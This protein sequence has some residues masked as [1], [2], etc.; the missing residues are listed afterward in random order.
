MAQRR[1]AGFGWRPDLPDFRDWILAVDAEVDATRLPAH[2]DL[3]DAGILPGVYDQGNLGS[4]T[5]NA[6]SADARAVLKTQKLGDVDPSRLY[7]YYKEREAEGSTGEDSGAFIRDGL[8]AVAK[9]FVPEAEWPYDISTF[10]N[11][12]RPIADLDRDA[13]KDHVIQYLR[14]LRDRGMRACLAAGFPFVFGISVYE[15]FEQATS[16]QIPMP[17]RGEAL[18]GGHAILAIGY[19]DQRRRYIFRNSWGRGWGQNGDG[20]IPYDYLHSSALSSAFWSIRKEA[21][22]A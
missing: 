18:L 22:T 17:G 16:G 5:A 13:Q 7:I 9:G 19:D 12:P 3:R 11:P 20:T 14:V 15:S 4:C 21:E 6:I 2:V 10:A 8:K 1:I